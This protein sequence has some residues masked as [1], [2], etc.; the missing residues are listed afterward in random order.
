[1]ADTEAMPPRL[2]FAAA[3]ATLMAVGWEETTTTD[4]DA[5]AETTVTAPDVA[6]TTMDAE[7]APCV[8]SG[9]P[10]SPELKTPEP[11]VERKAISLP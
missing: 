5:D 4:A 6:E 3:S 8:V 10:Y 9:S 1:M 11:Y 7:A 2:M